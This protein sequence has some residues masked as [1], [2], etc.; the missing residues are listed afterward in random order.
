[1]KNIENIKIAGLVLMTISL[2]F[3]VS[4]KTAGII[5]AAAAL[6]IQLIRK[7]NYVDISLISRGLILL[8]FSSLISTVFAH[9]VAKSFKGAMDVIKYVLVFFI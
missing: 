6:M 4:L 7:E 1:M 2:P 3:S 8:F 9:N 5:I